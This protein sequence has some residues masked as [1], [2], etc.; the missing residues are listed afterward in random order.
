MSDT[1][2]TKNSEAASSLAAFED[3][4]ALVEFPEKRVLR[5]TGKD[6]AGM[7]D[8][9]LTSDAP[10]E[11]NLGAYALLLDP[12][13]RMQTDLRAIKHGDDILA[14]VE[15]EGEEAAKSILGR[16]APFSRVKL[17]DTNFSVLGVYGSKAK[18]ILGL[19]LA[20]HGSEEVEIGDTKVLAVGVSVPASGCDLLV[21]EE[22][23]RHV[24]GHLESLGASSASVE[25]Y[26]TLRVEAGV[27]R[28]GADM[29]P[30]NFPGEAGILDR[31]VNFR[32]G[33]YPGQETVARMHYRGQP[34]KNL[35]RFVV[36]EGKAPEPGTSILQNEKDVG[37]ITSVAPLSVD[38]KTF[39]LG[40]LKRK[41]DPEG[42][43][44]AGSATL[45]H[46]GLC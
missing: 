3:G 15:A 23:I 33:C 7:L 34:N 41:A 10:K 27:P 11:E 32:K 44:R 22:N 38:G 31:A 26:E 45:S 21:S 37:K 25:E 9:I 36:V 18:E 35:H 5:L 12:K 8:A 30:D 2:T 42:N 29:T 17:E 40:Y 16:Y 19:E 24:R 43:L 28:F 13:G 1:R 4:A 20:E 46:E 6:P 14:V 39:A